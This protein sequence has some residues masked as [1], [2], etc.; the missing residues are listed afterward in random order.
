MRASYTEWLMM[1]RKHAQPAVGVIGE[2]TGIDAAQSR[3]R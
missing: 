3:D 2:Y 1:L